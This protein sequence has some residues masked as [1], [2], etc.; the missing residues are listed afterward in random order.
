[1]IGIGPEVSE[2]VSFENVNR[3]L[4]PDAGH[5]TP[6]DGRRAITK[7]HPDHMLRWAK[8]VFK[9]YGQLTY[10]FHI[11]PWRITLTWICHLSKMRFHE[12]HA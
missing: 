8:T 4:T 5:R 1:L 3:R 12:M 10:V 9:G 6:D 11:W 7:A 2:E